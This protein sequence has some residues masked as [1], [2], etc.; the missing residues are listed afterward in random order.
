MSIT[1]R[2]EAVQRCADIRFRSSNFEQV[3]AEGPNAQKKDLLRRLVKKV[4]IHDRRTVE[5]WYALPNARRFEHW[6]K[7]LPKRPGHLSG[8]SGGFCG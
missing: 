3:I 2:G 4:L 6:N 5:V 7:N 8:R 1:R